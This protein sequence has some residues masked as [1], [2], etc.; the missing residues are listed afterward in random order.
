MSSRTAKPSFVARGVEVSSP[1]RELYPGVTKRDL[2]RYYEL[3]ADA[4]LP[5]VTRRLLTLRRYPRGVGA[6]GFV[7]QHDNGGLPEAI[8]SVPVREAEGD[9]ESH[10]YIEDAAGLVAC[11]QMAVL[12]LHGWGSRIDDLDRPDRLVFD[13]DPD[14]SLTFADVTRA[15]LDIRDRLHDQGVE[16]WP[17]LSGGKGIHVVVALDEDHDWTTVSGFAKTFA[18][19]LSGEQ[20]DLY[21]AEMSKAERK[22]RIFIDWLRNQR[23]ATAVM[24]FST[25]TK[26]TASV[27]MPVGWGELDK[28]DSADAFTVRRVLGEGAHPPAAWCAVPQ[29][30]RK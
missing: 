21:L 1:D 29:S 26:P 25:R 22:S 28:L 27:A 12:E 8:R 23:G 19:K 13:L 11:V 6:P 17:L 3:V 2:V 30:L 14:P 9:V 5:H 24:P 15:A 20:P 18:E 7:Q 10:L 4:M 16:S